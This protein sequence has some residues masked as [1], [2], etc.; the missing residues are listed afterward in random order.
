MAEICASMRNQSLELLL[1]DPVH[2]QFIMFI[3][4]FPILLFCNVHVFKGGLLV[5]YIF[6]TLQMPMSSD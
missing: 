1:A 6:I 2:L 5:P 4:N 3:D